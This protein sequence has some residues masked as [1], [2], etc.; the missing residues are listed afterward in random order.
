MPD[1]PDATLVIP[2]IRGLISEGEIVLKALK[3]YEP[4]SLGISISN[5]A[6]EGLE[7]YLS[8]EESNAC[9][10]PENV[11]ED[12]YIAG[13]SRFGEVRKPPPCFVT[14]WRFGKERGAPVIAL[15]MNDSQFTDAYCRNVSGLDVM[16]SE[17]RE[18]KIARYKFTSETPAE[19]VLEW[20]RT[21][22]SSKGFRNLELERERWLANSINELRHKYKKLAVVIELERFAGVRKLLDEKG[23]SHELISDL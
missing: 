18:K 3:K 17:R 13:L 9:A 14:A 21:V 23:I 11:E 6:L 20:D 8:N 15:D 2:V 7:T 1:Y 19:F 5:E 10:E 22:N 12:V 4:D 16:F